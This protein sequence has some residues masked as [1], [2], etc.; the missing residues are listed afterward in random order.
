MAHCGHATTTVDVGVE[1][2]DVD[3]RACRGVS[4][5]EPP[6]PIEY[7]EVGLR[8]CGE[9]LIHNAEGEPLVLVDTAPSLLGIIYQLEAESV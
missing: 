5:V 6:A 9:N 1:D 3:I 2:A 8:S 7:I 4:L